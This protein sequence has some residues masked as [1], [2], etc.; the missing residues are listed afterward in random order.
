MVWTQRLLL[1][2]PGEELFVIGGEQVYR[3]TLPS[4][5]RLYLTR[6]HAHVAGDVMFPAFHEEQWAVTEQGSH[7]ADERNEYPM[8]FLRY[9]R[10]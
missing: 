1:L 9:D 6:V 5:A 3:M 7:A 2:E 8:T 4:A 10:R